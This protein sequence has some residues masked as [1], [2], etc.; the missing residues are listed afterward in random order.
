MAALSPAENGVGEDRC[1]LGLQARGPPALQHAHTINACFSGFAPTRSGTTEHRCGNEQRHA[2]PFYVES[3]LRYERV[4][5]K[6]GHGQA[7]PRSITRYGRQDSS[8]WSRSKDV[9]ERFP[10]MFRQR[11]SAD[12]WRLRGCEANLHETKR[13]QASGQANVR[14]T[15]VELRGGRH[16]TVIRKFRLLGGSTR[17]GGAGPHRGVLR[18]LS[19]A[20]SRYAAPG[21]AM[22]DLDVFGRWRFSPG[23]H[24]EVC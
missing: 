23:R 2:Q 6:A 17:G 1:S 19:R 13:R 5:I 4:E 22:P 16:S 18:D 12:V 21:R 9:A 8:T 3:R 15:R 20:L 14:P 7:P 11:P 10:A 24:K